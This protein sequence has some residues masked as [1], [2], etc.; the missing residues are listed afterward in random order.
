MQQISNVAGFSNLTPQIPV[1]VLVK[2]T[3]SR[4]NLNC[5]YCFYL[6]K[7]EL[8]PWGKHPKLTIDLYE[9][10]LEQYFAMSAPFLSFAWQGGEPTIMGLDF[11]EQIV[12]LQQKY[13]H[14]FN[15]MRSNPVYNSI[16]T[17]GT[18][19]NDD[20]A[21]FFKQNN[22][23][24]GISL[25]GPPEQ[26]DLYRQ[27]WSGRPT[28]D[29]V[30]A[31]IEFLRIRDVPFNVLTV[32]NQSNVQQPK[33]LLRWLAQQGFTH[34]QFI[35]LME[36]SPNM[37]SADTREPSKESLTPNQWGYFLSE[38]LEAW[39]EIGVDKLRIRWFDDVIHM[40]WGLPSEA[41][42]LAKKCGYIL[43][44]HNG[45]CYPCDFFV[46][47]TQL[48]GNIRN[49]SLVEMITSEKFKNFSEA[50]N[51]LH[52]DC[53]ECEWITLCY[54]ECPKYRIANTGKISHSLPYFCPSYKQF[55]SNNYSKLEKVSIQRAR[56]AGIVVPPDTLSANIR[57][58][59]KPMTLDDIRSIAKKN[60]VGRNGLCPCKSGR[61]YKRCCGD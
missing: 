30:M 51:K 61:K 7:A 10:F 9:E 59:T 3:S 58:R 35:P 2:P 27:D 5:S 6:S 33:K 16:Q 46:E 39:R 24:V 47:P 23:L 52:K 25:D 41:C 22:F 34:I 18:M 36:I 20:W 50:K 60:N 17:N 12:T 57:T 43:L 45:D 49:D 8:Y 21:R 1:G 11:Y 14:K 40:L 15:L 44:E 19:L 53:R 28:F 32:V 55:F 42:I 13:A 29:K 54:G 31:G 26:H 37:R 56:K 48:L 4:C 38:V